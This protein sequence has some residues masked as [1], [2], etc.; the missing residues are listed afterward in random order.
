[1]F[2]KVLFMVLIAIFFV[3]WLTAAISW[4]WTVVFAIRVLF[5]YREKGVALSRRTLF[6][7]LN[8]MVKPEL[9]TEE[10]QQSR[11]KSINGIRVFLIA[12]VVGA[13]AAVLMVLVQNK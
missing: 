8:A 5:Q 1:M 9:L 7:P 4:L 11:Q 12:W 2:L 13:V 3:S 10:G 6:N